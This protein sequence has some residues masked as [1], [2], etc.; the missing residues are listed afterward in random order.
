M[1]K[2]ILTLS[3]LS[4]LTACSLFEDPA[5]K[6]LEG[7][8]LSLYDFEK[9]LRSDPN[10]QFGLDGS[11]EQTLITLPEAL[12]G[13][14]DNGIS[15]DAPWENK[16]WPQV[17]GYPN[18]TMKH[19]AF[20]SD[21][22]RKLWSASIGYGATKTSPMTAAPVVADGKVFTLDTRSNV[23]ATNAQNGKV[24]WSQNILKSGED[25]SVISGGVAFS[26]NR[27]FV[28]NGFNEVVALNPENGSV[29]W[30]TTT[31]SPIRGA[32]SAV[33]GRIFVITMDNK[34]LALDSAKGNILWS[35]SGLSTDT[36]T[37]GASTPAIDKNSVITAYSSGEV[38]ALRIE[39]GQ[40]LWSENLAPVAR[41]AGR[42]QMS[43]IRALPIVDAGTVYATSHSNRMAA[44]DMRSGLARWNAAIGSTSTPWVSGNRLYIMSLQ[45]TLIS[46]NRTNGK[47]LWQSALPRY[48]DV[49]DREGA[50]TWN[51]PILAGNRLMAF[52]STG[53]VRDFNPA[54]DH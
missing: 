8:R 16:F 41:A 18:H 39:N 34:T 51:G 29:L 37:L 7:M 47:V 42:M 5:E 13:G 40:E 19:V 46:L 52:A 44:I 3:T 4:L 1:K 21:K 27:V 11:E 50:I 12:A 26:G 6:K 36:Q 35:H 14:V 30:R 54:D 53:E 49:E 23:Q 22:P 10:T 45:S 24:I 20:N 28:T 43:D 2:I 33:P 38:Y 32:P 15:L 17:G 25:E 31:K 48:E 9:T